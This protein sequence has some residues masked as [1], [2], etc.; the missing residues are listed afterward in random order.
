MQK[1]IDFITN[2]RNGI[3]LLILI[4]LSLFGRI[5][6]FDFSGFDD[7]DMIKNN[8]NFYAKVSNIGKAFSVDAFGSTKGNSFYRPLQTISF[9]L[10]YQLGK[11]Q[12][13]VYHLCNLILHILSVVL[14][15]MFLD[16]LGINPLAAILLTIFYSI[17]SVISNAVAWIPARGDLLVT[18]FILI[19]TISTIRYFQK[20]KLFFL[21][22]GSCSFLLAVF[23]KETALA[24]ILI[25][26]MLSIIF[27][28]RKHI[29]KIILVTGINAII[30]IFY[31]F[32]RSSVIKGSFLNK[33]WFSYFLKNIIGLP[34]QL[35]IFFLDP[36]AVN[37]L[38]IIN[39]SSWLPIL[40]GTLL[41]LII[42]YLIITS[43]DKKYP[44]FGILW[45]VLFMIP[46]LFFRSVYADFGF[47]Y[48]NHRAY[49]PFI[50]ILII[51][52]SFIESENLTKKIVAGVSVLIIALIIYNAI[53]TTI[54]IN[55]Y[56]DN[57]S[58]YSKAA[59]NHDN[60]FSNFCL[61]NFYLD[62][63]KPEEAVK[64]LEEAI[65]IHPNYGEAVANLSNILIKRAEYDK[66]IRV[67][68]DGVTAAPEFEPS[69]VN[70]GKLYFKKNKIFEGLAMLKKAADL[71]PNDLDVWYSIGAVFIYMKQYDYAITT[72]QEIVKL[73][74]KNFKSWNTLGICYVNNKDYSKAIAAFTKSLELKPND[75]ATKRNIA[76]AKYDKDVLDRSSV[77]TIR[78][79]AIL[80]DKVCSKWLM[81]HGM[82]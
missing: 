63:G 36:S 22:V 28:F 13:T 31:L 67:L 41:I 25:A 7:S 12:A 47:D 21:I 26:P 75:L 32:L 39:S 5:I 33:E 66:A 9:I 76:F 14:I 65:K 2:K 82:K 44:L 53:N 35:G 80:G 48:L 70:L 18:L 77:D 24:G 78:A 58:F 79:Y 27:G 81:D 60:S 8:S 56:R 38:P 71:A 51:F 4:N 50:G 52:Q 6:F 19:Y 54:Y 20:E 69:Y 74:S 59:E 62:R 10:D 29:K 55:T 34:H 68:E 43:K 40:F 49:L 73:D 1:A 45:L 61:S 46:T 11:D 72:Y 57:I 16:A 37:P 64:L 30:S 42:A 3:I 15:L 23:S 17:N